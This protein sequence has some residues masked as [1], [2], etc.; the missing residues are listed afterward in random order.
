MQRMEQRG[1]QRLC[2]Q[3]AYQ[4]SVKDAHHEQMNQLLHVNNAAKE[5]NQDNRVEWQRGEAVSILSGRLED[6][7]EEMTWQKPLTMLRET[8]PIRRLSKALTGLG[9]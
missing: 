6:P 3:R 4:F 5:T 9:W 2:H 8:S 7:L 1:G